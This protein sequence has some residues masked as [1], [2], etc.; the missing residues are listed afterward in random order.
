[1]MKFGR[2]GVAG[3]SPVGAESGSLVSCPS[4]HFHSPIEPFQCVAAAFAADIPTFPFT[5]RDRRGVPADLPHRGLV[6]QPIAPVPCTQRGARAAASSHQAC[7]FLDRRLRQNRSHCPSKTRPG[8]PLRRSRRAFSRNGRAEGPSN[9]FHFLPFLAPNRDLSTRYGREASRNYF[10]SSFFRDEG[11]PRFKNS[12]DEHWPR[13]P[14]KPASRFSPRAPTSCSIPVSMPALRPARPRLGD[15]KLRTY[16]EH[17]RWE[18]KCL[19]V[20]ALIA[21][22]SFLQLVDPKWGFPYAGGIS[23]P[24]NSK[25]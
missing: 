17:R 6:V 19:I 25:G 18:R 2:L 8:A 14:K 15:V 9:A 16:H 22:A 10:L 23:S 24:S 7:L 1:M 5:R 4:S 20:C 21:R 13:R 12:E 3:A 11:R